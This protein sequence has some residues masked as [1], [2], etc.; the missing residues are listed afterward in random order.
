MKMLYTML[1]MKSP[2]LIRV[3]KIITKVNQNNQH[4]KPTSLPRE[5]R[6]KNSTYVIV[7]LYSI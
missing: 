1:A 4:V 5:K 3:N 7:I 2:Q 6:N